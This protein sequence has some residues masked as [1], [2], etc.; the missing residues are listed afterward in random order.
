MLDV[1]LQIFLIALVVSAATNWLRKKLLS[2]QDMARMKESQK[3][4]KMLLEAKQK[5]DKKALQKLMKK[6]E[7]YQ[8]IDAEI[9]KKNMILLFGSL[10]IF[11][12]VYAILTPLYGG[13]NIVATLP[14]DLVIPFLSDENKLS[15]I[16]W[17]ILS[18]LA[19]NMP[20]GKIFEV[21]PEMVI[22]HAEKDAKDKKQKKE[23]D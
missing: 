23:K 12:F 1:M 10:G 13:V 6:Q 11:Y 19:V 5:G 7:Y 21:K 4:K 20:L 8:K 2:P 9:G 17:F 15:F 16:G 3:F 14:G 18:L 22:Q